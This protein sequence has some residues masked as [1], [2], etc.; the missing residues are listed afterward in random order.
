MFT[1]KCQNYCN[2][3]NCRALAVGVLKIQEAKHI[4][5]KRK[6]LKACKENLPSISLPWIGKQLFY[7]VQKTSTY[8][9]MC[10]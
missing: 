10:H 1:S 4:L 3:V 2:D 8:G 6:V 9:H 5:E 7:S